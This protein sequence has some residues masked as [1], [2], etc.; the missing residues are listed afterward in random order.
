MVAV[1]SPGVQSR[2]TF[3]R[4]RVAVRCANCRGGHL[5]LCNAPP[6]IIGARVPEAYVAI[7]EPNWC[8]RI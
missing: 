1:L 2:N 3:V 5:G 6:A 4:G 7:M 8:P